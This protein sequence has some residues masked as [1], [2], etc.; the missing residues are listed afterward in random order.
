MAKRLRFFDKD[1]I[2][3]G[4][5]PLESFYQTLMRLKT[6]N[7]LIASGAGGGQMTSIHTG[8]EKETYAFVRSKGERKLLV[9]LNFS[10]TDQEIR[11]QGNAP[12]G[13]YKEIFTGETREWKEGTGMV[14]KPWQYLVYESY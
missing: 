12:E 7:D 2:P 11:L 6:S 14:L 13:R 3:W 5:Y 8:K 10:D 9:L 1:T 4:G